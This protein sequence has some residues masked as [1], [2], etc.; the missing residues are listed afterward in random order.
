M[1][2]KNDE[3][4]LFLTV[5]SKSASEFARWC[6]AEGLTQA[7]GFSRLLALT[8]RVREAGT[9]LDDKFPE[10]FRKARGKITPGTLP[11]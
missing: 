7:K 3:C 1:R 8:R 5:S 9:D 2:S 11:D 4:E 10:A 6:E